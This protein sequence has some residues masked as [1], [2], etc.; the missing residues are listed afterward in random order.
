MNL[1][2]QEFQNPVIHAETTKIDITVSF[3]YTIKAFPMSMSV[4]KGHKGYYPD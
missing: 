4:I 1:I 3:H 2:D